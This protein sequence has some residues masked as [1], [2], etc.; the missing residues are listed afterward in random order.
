MKTAPRDRR[1]KLHL[2]GSFEIK[3]A[4]REERTFEGSL[5]TSHLDLGDFFAR[6]IVWPGAFRRTIDHF[7][8]ARDPYVPLLDSHSPYSIFNTLG[9][10]LDAEEKLTGGTLVYTMAAGRKL[11][12]PEMQLWTKWQVVDGV[13]GDRVLDRLRPGSIRKMSMG[14]HAVQS[15]SD[16]LENGTPVRLLRE[17]ELEEGSLVVFA[18]NPEAQVDLATVKAVQDAMAGHQ[19]TDEQKDTLRALL[20]GTPAGTAPVAP[21]APEPKGLAPEDP[22]RLALE[23]Q[24]RGLTL[25]GLALQ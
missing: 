4:S 16:E 2:P 9:H 24:L 22:H 15:S 21:P 13:D 19:L 5:S 3:A 7:K 18:M 6:D 8:A 17:V 11:E 23:H 14:Y 1:V 10:L 25:R 12:V 20:D